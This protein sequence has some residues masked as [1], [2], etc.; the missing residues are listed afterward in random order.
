MFFIFFVLRS[1]ILV[2]YHKQVNR[3]ILNRS[4]WMSK[5]NRPFINTYHTVLIRELSLNCS[6]MWINFA[7]CLQSFPSN[8]HWN[9]IISPLDGLWS[10]LCSEASLCLQKGQRFK[11]ELS[12]TE[13]RLTSTI[14]VLSPTFKFRDCHAT[15]ESILFP[16]LG[17]FIIFGNPER[18]E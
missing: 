3:Y 12:F 14:P 7:I 11:H 13:S 18:S 10:G 2:G 5:W 17:E 9:S 16:R 15:L 8:L 6:L 1:F 4:L